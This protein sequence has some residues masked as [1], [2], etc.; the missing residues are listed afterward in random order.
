MQYI[1]TY[2]HTYEISSSRILVLE[3]GSDPLVSRR[4]ALASPGR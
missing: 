1:H 2:T 4:F 3:L